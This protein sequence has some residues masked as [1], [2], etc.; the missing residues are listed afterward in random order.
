[1][2]EKYILLRDKRGIRDADV[3]NA[4]GIPASTF[5][6]WKKGRSE[7]KI[8]KLVKIAKFFEVPLSYFVE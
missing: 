1:M 2:Y 8:E 5:S 6:D 3:A 7:P 4:T